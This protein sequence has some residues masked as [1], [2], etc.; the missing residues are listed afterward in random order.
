MGEDRDKEKSDKGKW[1]PIVDEYFVITCL[2]RISW[3]SCSI[4]PL[5][6]MLLL[7]L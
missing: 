2:A 6:Q 7:H 4:G 5:K 3:A 1:I